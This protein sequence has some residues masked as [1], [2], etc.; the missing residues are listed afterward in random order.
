M[1]P[2]GKGSQLLHAGVLYLRD[3]DTK[4][5]AVTLTDHLAEA[6]DL[7]IRTGHHRIEAEETGQ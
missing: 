2:F 1:V 5:V 4:R 7:V 6:L 3:P